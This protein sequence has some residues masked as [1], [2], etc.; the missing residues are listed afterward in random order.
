MVYGWQ[1]LGEGMRCKASVLSYYLF[2]FISN[3]H[4]SISQS[5]AVL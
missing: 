5:I 1:V 4:V 2:S 3:I